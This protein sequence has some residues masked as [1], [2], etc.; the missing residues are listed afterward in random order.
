MALVFTYK[1]EMTTFIQKNKG[2]ILLYQ[3][4]AFYYGGGEGIRTPAP[5]T[6][7]SL[8]KRDPSTTWVLL[9]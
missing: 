7:Y 6:A 9:Q 5:V 8:S 4:I 2:S 1:K 3:T